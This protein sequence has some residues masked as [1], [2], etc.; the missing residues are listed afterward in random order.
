MIKLFLIDDSM[1]IRNSIKKILSKYDDLTIIGEASNP[2]DAFKEFKKVG[3]PDIF[4][5]DIEMPHMTGIEFLKLMKEQKPVPTIICS[6]AAKFGS[7]NAIEA[8]ELGACDI[9]VKDSFDLKTTTQI[10]DEFITKIRAAACS[11]VIDFNISKNTKKLKPFKSTNKIIAI[12]SSTGGV[13]TIEKILLE[14][15]PNHPPIVITQHM[16]KG[17]TASFANRLNEI[18][19]NSYIKEANNNDPL[20]PGQ[21]L[22]APGD[23]HLEVKNIKEN[24]YI[25]LLKDF[26]KV[27]NHKPSV[28]V[29]F[30]SLSKEVKG[31]GIAFILTGMGK[32]GALGIK[33][34]KDQGG[35]TYGQNEESSIVYG[36]PKVAFEIGAIQKQISIDEVAEIINNIEFEG[37]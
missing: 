22:I 14:L 5:L 37:R 2:V 11:K 31:N 23:L 36:M 20:L 15:R 29:L 3:L 35:K 27:S 1:A 13:Q 8:L 6:G 9:I 30:S 32:D 25:A 24:R 17:F 33:K 28:D 18:C 16:P 26:P 21:V 34:I 4:I 7:K 10:S 12:G 19:E